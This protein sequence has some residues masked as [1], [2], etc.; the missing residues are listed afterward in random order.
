MGEINLFVRHTSHL[1][2]VILTCIAFSLKFHKV[3]TE[4]L[5][6]AKTTRCLLDVWG[7]ESIYVKVIR[8]LIGFTWTISF[9]IRLSNSHQ[10]ATT[11]LKSKVIWWWKWYQEKSSVWW[12]IPC[13][14]HT[15]T[16]L[17]TILTVLRCKMLKC[18]STEA[19]IIYA[20]SF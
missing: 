14:H 12:R 8:S 20:S 2:P 5:W 18:D 1:T 17:M 15:I 11:S 10:V 3:G 7:E 9:Q 6:S 4:T 19:P 16:I 13:N